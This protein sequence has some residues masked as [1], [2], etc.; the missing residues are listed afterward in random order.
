MI[1]IF[2]AAFV[3]PVHTSFWSHGTRLFI[4]SHRAFAHPASSISSHDFFVAVPSCWTAVKLVSSS[5]IVWM[6]GE[7]VLQ[8]KPYNH[9]VHPKVTRVTPP[10]RRAVFLSCMS[11]L[12]FFIG[13]FFYLLCFVS[14]RYIGHLHLYLCGEEIGFFI[15]CHIEHVWIGDEESSDIRERFDE[16]ECLCTRLC[17]KSRRNLTLSSSREIFKTYFITYYT[18]GGIR[19]FF[20]CV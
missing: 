1:A 4:V 7:L 14:S 15:Y 6:I 5:A 11:V 10:Q 12:A 8:K 2:F 19:K 13:E 16:I 18:C 17:R 9:H 3:V 20:R